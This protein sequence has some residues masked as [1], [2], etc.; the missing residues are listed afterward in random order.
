MRSV[1]GEGIQI[2]S[3]NEKWD[4]AT[5][6][7]LT[8][9]SAYGKINFLDEDTTIQPEVCFLPFIINRIID[10]DCGVLSFYSR[11]DMLG[12]YGTVRILK[13][14]VSTFD[15]LRVHIPGSF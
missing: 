12:N 1:H 15:L 4:K 2:H 3:E 10:L 8:E 5:H 11:I 7:T 6:T 14:D 9:C 13:C